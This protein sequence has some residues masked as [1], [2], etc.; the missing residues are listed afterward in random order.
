MKKEYL[1]VISDD[2]LRILEDSKEE[3]EVLSIITMSLYY[4]LNKYNRDINTAI[5]LIKKGA[6]KLEEF[7]EV[8]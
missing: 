6:K 5:T 7:M 2:L 4:Y 8:K 1:D 3:S